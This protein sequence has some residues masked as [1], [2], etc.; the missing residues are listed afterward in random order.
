MF[1]RLGFFT[2]LML[3]CPVLCS[4]VGQAKG[5][6]SCHC[7]RH[8]HRL[9]YVKLFACPFTLFT[10]IIEFN[11]TQVPSTA[12]CTLSASIRWAQASLSALATLIKRHSARLQFR[13]A[14]SLASTP[15]VSLRVHAN[16]LMKIHLSFDGFV[17]CAAA[18]YP[19]YPVPPGLL[20]WFVV[21]L[22]F[23]V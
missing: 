3:R 17:M 16:T 23:C 11:Q 13:R 7:P 18:A 9:R 12:D 14:T 6:A 19:P 10:L 22:V 5:R 1:V 4:I 15:L 8:A 20:L 2:V 21:L